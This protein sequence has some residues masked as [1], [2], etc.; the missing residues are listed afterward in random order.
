M[1]FMLLAL[2]NIDIP[3][4]RF[5]IIPQGIVPE[6]EM[7]LISPQCR[8]TYAGKEMTTLV[9]N[10]PIQEDMGKYDWHAMMRK[11]VIAVWTATEEVEKNFITKEDADR[12][13]TPKELFYS[14]VTMLFTLATWMVKDCCVYADSYY[15][16]NTDNGYSVK[17]KR[18]L[19]QTNSQGKTTVTT[20][21]E[22]EIEKALEYLPLL[23]KIYMSAIDNE[24]AEKCDVNYSQGTLVCDIESAIKG[25]GDSFYRM[26]I[27]LQIARKTGFLP[28]KIS[29]YCAIL[30]CL[31]A[32][33]KNHK[34]TITEMTAKFIAKDENEK[35][36]IEQDMRCAYGV[37]SDFVHGDVNILFDRIDEL[38]KL[39]ERIDDYVRKAVQ[40]AFRDDDYNYE[41]TSEDKS[42]VRRYFEKTLI[43]LTSN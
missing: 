40:R 10:S 20:F 4:V 9:E 13:Y 31:F 3:P 29:M 25:N 19:M 39:S 36:I 6:V 23:L 37:R 2:S 35:L 8:F 16:C 38:S 12:Y 30:E 1:N 14:D 21:D 43:N 7:Y 24:N 42:R 27:L 17:G 41:S 15:W 22:N 28:E 26:I 32:I 5:D 11:P 33:E 34:K 18:D